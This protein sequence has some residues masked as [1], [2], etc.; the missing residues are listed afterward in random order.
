MRFPHPAK[1]ALA[2]LIN[3]SSAQERRCK[4]CFMDWLF[5]ACFLHLSFLSNV[6]CWPLVQVPFVSVF[7]LELKYPAV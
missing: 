4:Y 1:I 6:C 3:T 7:A 5:H 2:Y